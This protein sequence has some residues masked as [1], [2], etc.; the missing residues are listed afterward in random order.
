MEDWQ[1]DPSIA[2]GTLSEEEDM[3]CWPTARPRIPGI[4]TLYRAAAAPSPVTA[5]LVPVPASRFSVTAG[6]LSVTAALVLIAMATGCVTPASAAQGNLSGGVL[7]THHPAQLQYSA[8]YDYCDL[9]AS[10]FAI[11][12]CAQQHNRVDINGADEISVWYVIAAWDEPKIWCGT[13]FGFGDFNPQAFYFTDHGACLP[14]HLELATGGWPGPREGTAVVATDTPW[15]GNFI[16]VYFFA[17]RAYYVDTIALGVD[18]AQQFAGFGNCSVP[19]EMW[20]AQLG[21]LGVFTDGVQLCPP[22]AVHACCDPATGDCLMLTAGE[23]AA[24]DGTWL[25]DMDSCDPDPCTP[26]PALLPVTWGEIRSLYQ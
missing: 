23:C 4:A 26:T 9:Y 13:E 22:E 10:E 11:S 18:P 7:I 24:L 16:P 2:E 12:S 17:G 14:N 15:E 1:P 5:T 6:R 25:Q 19:A 3:S 8:G 21:V 20:S